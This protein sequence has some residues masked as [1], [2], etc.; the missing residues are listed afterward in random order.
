[1]SSIS[2]YPIILVHGIGAKDNNLFWGR[3]P[4]KMQNMGLNVLLGNTDSWGST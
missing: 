3:I 4:K 2:K 1:M